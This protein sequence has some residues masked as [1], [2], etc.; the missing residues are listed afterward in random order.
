MKKTIVSAALCAAFIMYGC[1]TE[2]ARLAKVP[3]SVDVQR[4][5]QDLF[6]INDSNFAQKT[7]MLQEKYGYFFNIFCNSVI[8]VGSPDSSAYKDNLLAFL[9]DSIVQS[10]YQSVQEV[11]KNTD[12]LN[13]KL[14]LAF[15]RFYLHFPDAKI[16]KIYT[17]TA[18]FNQSVVLTDSVIGIGLD[19]YLGA[20]YPLY[21]KMG[22]YRYLQR[23]MYPARAPVDA[24]RFFA[25]SM[26]P[27]TTANLLQRI[28]WEGKILYFTHQ[29][30]P[31][32][33]DSCIFGFSQQQISECLKNEAYM[34]D[35]LVADG[36]LFSQDFRTIRDMVEE[37]PFSRRFSQEAPGR[38]AVWLGFRIVE[39][40]MHSNRSVSLSQLMRNNNAQEILDNSKYSPR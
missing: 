5:E 11:F 20:G 4:F 28:I 23:N 2:R 33:P 8:F 31:N 10:G 37:A 25:G 27:A 24:I 1:D 12:D 22:F 38:A 3:V 7:A 18:G 30:L 16:P 15:K 40:Y 34:W 32:E 17:F 14:T 35:V 26:F 29:L 13:E 36:L 39:K 19:K 9:H 21:T 6:A